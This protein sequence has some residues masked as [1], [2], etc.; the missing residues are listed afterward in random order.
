MGDIMRTEQEKK[1]KEEQEKKAKARQQ[2]LGNGQ[3]Q[4]KPESSGYLSR[5]RNFFAP[6]EQSKTTKSTSAVHKKGHPQ[7]KSEIVKST[8][9]APSQMK[10][11]RGA[12]VDDTVQNG[13][14]VDNVA[15]RGKE[16]VGTVLSPVAM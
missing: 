10:R 15:K 14:G 1:V 3:R 6:K 2:R 8:S 5:F 4:Q 7:R 13:G 16:I 12:T 9:H 11:Q